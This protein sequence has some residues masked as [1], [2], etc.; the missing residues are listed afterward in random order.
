MWFVTTETVLDSGRRILPFSS[1]RLSAEERRQIPGVLSRVSY[2]DW[3]EGQSSQKRKQISEALG[4]EPA[5][6]AIFEAS[7]KIDNADQEE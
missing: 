2:R 6:N 1:V 3:L 5:V 4:C 7:V